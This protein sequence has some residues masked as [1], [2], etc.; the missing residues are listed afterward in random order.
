MR[1]LSVLAAATVI[2][3]ASIA[4]V[5]FGT[6]AHAA[7]GNAVLKGSI[8]AWANSKN[9]VSAADPTGDVGFRVYLGWNNAS[10]VE[11]L[12]AALGGIGATEGEA[13][14]VE[15]RHP[16]P[17]LAAEGVEAG[18]QR[19]QVS[20]RPLHAIRLDPEQQLQLEERVVLQQ[21]DAELPSVGSALDLR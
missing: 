16:K 2:G 14:Q 21:L 7:S 20:A 1:R 17:V 8:P 9:L 3:T 10:A 4:A 13:K 11:S 19:F 15:A 5:S 6:A 18:E 12:A